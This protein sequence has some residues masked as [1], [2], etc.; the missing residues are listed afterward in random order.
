MPP[1]GALSCM[2]PYVVIKAIRS[3]WVTGRS[4]T[5]FSRQ[6]MHFLVLQMTSETERIQRQMDSRLP[7]S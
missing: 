5:R 6:E 4:W 3:K 2:L 1:K 7:M